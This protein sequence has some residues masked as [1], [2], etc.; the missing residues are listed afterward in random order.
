MIK[1]NNLMNL[2]FT[3]LLVFQTNLIISA[4][5]VAPP[6][7]SSVPVA[8]PLD[9]DDDGA[10][11]APPLDDGSVPVAPPAPPVSPTLPPPAPPIQAKPFTLTATMK[12][13][14]I[15][16]IFKNHGYLN[17]IQNL[18]DYTTAAEKDL[19]AKNL[20]SAQSNLENA[21]NFAVAIRDSALKQIDSLV[22]LRAFLAKEG[23]YPQDQVHNVTKATA[24][25]ALFDSFDPEHKA[26]NEYIKR[27]KS[28]HNALQKGGAIS[29]VGPQPKPITPVFGKKLA[30]Q[31]I[32]VMLV[33][34][35]GKEKEKIQVAK[36]SAEGLVKHVETVLEKFSKEIE[37]QSIPY[38]KVKISLKKDF[39]KLLEY[40][41]DTLKAQQEKAEAAIIT[42]RVAT[43]ANV[44]NDLIKAL[45]NP[46]DIPTQGIARGSGKDTLFDN[47]KTILGGAITPTASGKDTTKEEIQKL[48]QRVSTLV[49]SS[50]DKKLKELF[51][52]EVTN[53]ALN[54]YITALTKLNNYT[55]SLNNEVKK[56]LDL[57]IANER[58]AELQ[59]ILNKLTPVKPVG[60]DV[61]EYINAQVMFDLRKQNQTLFDKYE[62]LLKK[63]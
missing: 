59:N 34:V 43:L 33:P 1:K 30:S 19:L 13:P 46:T 35:S 10:P 24:Q 51:A 39:E 49:K 2:F 22:P 7:D 56:G 11:D 37:A 25:N 48:E 27:L 57:I 26:A 31:I 41:K 61:K 42:Q 58:R 55:K 62:E 4:V 17:A 15:T 60:I 32:P 5:P 50:N 8:P 54:N 44:F 36:I 16:N 28:I 21:V 52:T 63:K 23:L 12:T 38:L 3:I 18:S 9:G 53:I 14:V 29:P 45:T 47:Y 20:K 6:L 40:A